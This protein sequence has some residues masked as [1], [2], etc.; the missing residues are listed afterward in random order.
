MFLLLHYRKAGN[1]CSHEKLLEAAMEN[2]IID[3]IENGKKTIL[4]LQIV[5][6]PVTAATVAGIRNKSN[7]KVIDILLK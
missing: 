7:S 2:I 4:S 1:K 5:F 6:N 3:S